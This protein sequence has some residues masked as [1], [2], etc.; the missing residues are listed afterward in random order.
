MFRE[1]GDEHAAFTAK[2]H[3]P[4]A[5]GDLP[6]TDDSLEGQ[7]RE[8]HTNLVVNFHD[9]RLILF[10]DVGPLRQD[11]ESIEMPLHISSSERV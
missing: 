7:D 11:K 4:R 6:E 1:E 3:G 5:H 9:Q 10:S 2:G 8:P